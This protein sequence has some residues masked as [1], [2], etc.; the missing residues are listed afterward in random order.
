MVVVA[1][2][3]G[4]FLYL[5]GLQERF[6]K[7][8]PVSKPV[9]QVVFLEENEEPEEKEEE[10]LTFDQFM[11]RGEDFLNDGFYT[12]AIN[13]FTSAIALN[14][15]NK[16]AY[17]KLIHAYI[18]LRDFAS[19]EKVAKNALKKFPTNKVFKL[20]L[21][22]IYIQKSTFDQAKD[23]FAKLGD[24]VPEKYFFLGLMLAFENQHQE[25]RQKLEIAKNSSLKNKSEIILSA[26]NEYDLFAT[27]NDLHLRLLIARSFDQL[28]LYE[29]AI[30]STKNIIKE[31][32][33]YR[34]AWIILGHA[35]LSLEK[36]SFAK[37]A[38]S[39]AVELD[40]TKS[41]SL[42]FLALTEKEL[43]NTEEA[44]DYMNKALK[45]GYEPKIDALKYLADLY[46]I[47]E[48]YTLSYKTYEEALHLSDKRV[49][50]F[51]RPMWILID[52]LKDYDKAEEI[53]KW[54]VKT[55]SR[56]AMSYNLLAWAKLENGKFDESGVYIKRALELDPNLQAAYL[57]RGKLY[58]KKG[59]TQKAMEDYKKSYELDPNSSI[60][61]NAA[62]L[63][64]RIIE[65]Q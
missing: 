45:N 43:G 23:Q 36:Y 39:K 4:T 42:F 34:D 14:S 1:L 26:Y 28:G 49:N 57:N 24:D 19:A 51:I 63:F 18:V 50:D 32:Q 27:E 64:N 13:N 59:D 10:N 61:S 53:G 41:E 29:M 60:G 37:D 65:T 55:H 5:P 48:N 54:A 58:E 15:N 6:G 44:I 17:E 38:L 21:G 2:G 3:L 33:E 16:K 52:Y 35:Y 46:L 8:D 40:S 12:L 20:L 47:A 56:E 9:P 7:K 22:E 11:E 31:N 25:A 30:Q 62:F